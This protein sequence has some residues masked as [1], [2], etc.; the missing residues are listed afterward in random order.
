[1]RVLVVAFVVDVRQE[2]VQAEVLIVSRRVPE[3]LRLHDG[4]AGERGVDGGS[5]RRPL[6]A[7]EGAEGLVAVVHGATGEVGDA[8]V[9]AAH[10]DE[11][12]DDELAV[13]GTLAAAAAL[14]ERAD[15]LRALGEAEGEETVREAR[16]GEEADALLLH[17]VVDVSEVAM[18]GVGRGSAADHDAVDVHA[19]DGRL[20]EALQT[21]HRT[22][23][24]AVI[25]HC[26]RG[27]RRGDV[28][29][30]SR[31]RDQIWDGSRGGGARG[32]S[33]RTSVPHN[34]GSRKIIVRGLEEHPRASRRGQREREDRAQQDHDP[35]HFHE[36]CAGACGARPGSSRVPTF[37]NG[38]CHY[39]PARRGGRAAGMSGL[40]RPPGITST[41]STSTTGARRAADEARHAM[42]SAE[43][44]D[45]HDLPLYL[46]E[47]LKHVHR[48]SSGRGRG[49]STNRHI[50]AAAEYFQAVATGRHVVGRD[51]AFVQA[52]QRNR[53]A[54]LLAFERAFADSPAM[55][56]GEWREA[57]GMLC[58]DVPAATV[59]DAFDAALGASGAPLGTPDDPE[60]TPPRVPFAAFFPAMA[61][62]ASARKVYVGMRFRKSSPTRVPTD[63]RGCRR[64]RRHTPHSNDRR[65][66]SRGARGARTDEGGSAVPG[67]GGRGVGDVDVRGVSVRGGFRARFVRRRVASRVD[68]GIDSSATAGARTREDNGGARPRG[69]R[70][71]VAFS[72]G[73][74]RAK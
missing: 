59:E 31:E 34:D 41:P 15:E 72:R 71:G 44:L 70:S 50:E 47:A 38:L 1:M 2:W 7:T 63:L 10:R 12:A 5:Y 16:L 65:R 4:G 20:H 11:A 22:G 37:Q 17:L 36:V 42:P 68:G 74:A 6:P 13:A 9:L 3:I 55:P 40:V 26:G 57:L 14:D 53:H 52:T 67:G 29:S 23:V 39:D 66:R 32:A 28:A 61:K 56:V 33:R 18:K 19:G 24:A 21:A 30:A 45:A 54:F 46:V 49:A 25:A 8:R 73:C 51:F 35:A 27:G 43:Y 62:K 60:G 64:G 69:R 48:V 58:P